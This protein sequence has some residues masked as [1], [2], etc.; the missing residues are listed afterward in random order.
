MP[1]RNVKSSIWLCVVALGSMYAPCS[2]QVQNSAPVIVE[3]GELNFGPHDVATTTPKTLIVKNAST[4]SVSPSVAI[5]GSNSNDFSWNSNCLS[6]LSPA[7]QCNVTVFF[8][9]LSISKPEERQAQLVVSSGNL[10]VRVTLTGSAFQNLGVAS[11]YLDFG[12]RPVNT[13]SPPLSLVVTNYSES[14]IRT[15]TATVTGDF[16]ESHSR[17]EEIGPGASCAISVIFAPKTPGLTKGSLTIT[18]D[19]SNV[20]KTP[21]VVTLEGNASVRCSAVG[22]S[23]WNWHVLLALLIGG[24]YFTGLVLVRWHT[25]AKPA[26]AQLVA[27]VNALR[28]RAIAETAGL[29]Q[30]ADLNGRLGRI[31][32]LL[33][34]ALYSFKNKTFPVKSDENGGQNPFVPAWPPWYTRLLNALFWPR[35]QELAGWSCVHEAEFELVALLPAERVRAAMEMSEPRLRVIN[36]PVSLALADHIH[37]TLSSAVFPQILER[38]RALLAEALG[39]IYECGD[40]DYFQLASW[41][42]KLMWLVVCAL[43]FIFALAATLQN[44]IL[45]LLGAVGG[46]LSR[47]ARTVS[48]ADVANDYGASWGTLF[49]SPLCGALSAWGGILLVVLGLKFNIFGSALNV[50]WCNPYEPAT[51]AIA[52]LLGFSERLFD[53]IAS[54]I[55]NKFLKAPPDS[56]PTP[57]APSGKP[58]PSISSLDPP[59]AILEQPVSFTVKG[60][61]FAPGAT[62]TVTDEHGNLTPAALEFT[63]PSTVVVKVTLGGQKAYTSALTISNPDKQSATFKFSVA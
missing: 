40:T 4:A 8:T 15:L 31:H 48:A 46:L 25:I 63:D 14:T 2:G 38:A 26:R 36:T 33:D 10:P 29:P 1:M 49:L 13:S 6:N 35:G 5:T 42:A 44:A 18:A 23:F 62:A 34:W 11:S 60:G 47:L 28:A 51:L 59:S 54:Q 45:L 58:G 12:D 32:Y 20:S 39:L 22:F 19:P 9:P 16:E 50:D 43:L 21:R 61:N 7:S 52:L 24:F 3:P 57:K 53:G 56:T 30:S 27:A 17:C 37:E 41:H 55:E